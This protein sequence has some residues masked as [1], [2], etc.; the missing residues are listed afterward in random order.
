MSWVSGFDMI[1]FGVTEQKQQEL[2]QRMEACNLRE[3]DLIETFVRASGPGGQRVNKTSTCVQLKHRPSGI[4]V[5]MQKTRSQALNRFYARRRMC[6]QLEARQLGE[7]SP[8]HIKQ[9]KIR[10]Q[11]Q[12]RQRRSRSHPT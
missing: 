8:L 7:K 3:S 6:E 1:N 9:E 2:T 10:K 12:R 4:E 5:K 11:K